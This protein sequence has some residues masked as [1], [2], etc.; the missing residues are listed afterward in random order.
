ML[1]PRSC[2]AEKFARPSARRDAKPF[3]SALKVV[4]LSMPVRKNVE[5]YG[6][7][8]PA[9]YLY[10]VIEGAVRCYKILDDGRRQISAFYFPGDIFGLEAGGLHALSAE[11][12]VDS[13]V[14]LIKRNAMFEIAARDNRVARDLWTLVA[15]E[16]HRMQEHATILMMSAQERVV[17]FLFE[18]ADRIASGSE[19]DLPMSRADIADFLGLTIETVSRTLTQLEKSAAIALPTCHHVVLRDCGRASLAP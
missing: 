19:I 15:T 18:I 2:T 17:S 6:E 1:H 5:I 12:I 8:Q 4:G 10:K 7:N 14:L 3:L 13:K 9:D 11:A 16:L